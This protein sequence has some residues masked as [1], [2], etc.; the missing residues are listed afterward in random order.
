MVY[1]YKNKG[2]NSN[3]CTY[4]FGLDFIKVQFNDGSVYLYN[5]SSTSMTCVE[6]MKKLALKGI[7]LNSYIGK[8]VK[9]NYAAKLR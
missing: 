7:G 9:K 3:V 1:H 8:T 2:G 5:Y 4:T 6:Q